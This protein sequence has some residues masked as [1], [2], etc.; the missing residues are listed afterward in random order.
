MTQ[1][2]KTTKRP[3]KTDFNHPFLQRGTASGAGCITGT[4]WNTLKK[5]LTINTLTKNNT[6]KPTAKHR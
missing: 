4:K 6:I 5:Q 3:A 1:S 2:H